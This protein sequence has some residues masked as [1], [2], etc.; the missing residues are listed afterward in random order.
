MKVKEK[1]FIAGAQSPRLISEL[2]QAGADRGR[3]IAELERQL[4][5]LDKRIAELGHALRTMLVAVADAPEQF[6]GQNTAY[7]Q[8]VAI[9]RAQKALTGEPE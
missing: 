9:P 1:V 2:M 6:P 7:L 3:R 4:A 8:T 5:E